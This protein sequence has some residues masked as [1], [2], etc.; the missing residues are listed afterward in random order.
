MAR[1]HGNSGRRNG[2]RLLLVY[3][4]VV[5]LAGAGALAWF[6]RSGLDV[7]PTG[8]LV[9]LV[10]GMIAGEIFPMEIPWRNQSLQVTLSST[11]ALMVLFLYG[12]AT[13]GTFHAVLWIVA[14]SLRRKGWMKVAFNAGQIILVTAAT[15]IVSSLLGVTP[16]AATVALTLDRTPELLAVIA[17][18]FAFLITN[19]VLTVIAR[20]LS[21]D[22]RIQ[23]VVRSNLGVEV[24]IEFA[25][26]LLVPVGLVS[27]S[28]GFVL[29][30]LTC[31]PIAA[32]Y[33]AVKAS[34]EN[35]VLHEER[36]ERLEA[37]RDIEAQLRQA[38]KMEA[39]GRLAG[40]VAHDFNNL[41][42]VILN[43]ARFAKDDLSEASSVHGDLDEIV[44]AAERATRLTQQLLS[45][46]RRDVI[47]PRVLQL[48]DVVLDM[49]RMLGRTI[50][51]HIRIS[52]DVDAAPSVYI[53]PGQLEQIILNLVVNARDA[54]PSGG[55]LV[56]RTGSVSVETATKGGRLPEGEFARLEVADTGGGIGSDSLDRI[57]EP[58][59][60]T[61]ERGEGT[62]LGLATVYGAVDQAGGHID[63]SSELGVGTVFSV[64]LP[65]TDLESR[66]PEMDAGPD[67]DLAGRTVLVVEDEASVRALVVRMLD[68]W[69]VR[70]LAASSG[71]EGLEISAGHVGPLDLVL[72]DVVMPRMSGKEFATALLGGRPGTPVLY[73]SGYTDDVVA[74]QGVLQDGEHLLR[75]PFDRAGLRKAVSRALVRRTPAGPPD[76]QP[77]RA[78]TSGA[79][80]D[81]VSAI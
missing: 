64:Y 10:L 39:I 51:E 13:A 40:G 19:Q 29:F 68:G 62:G 74:K 27:L 33:F 60:T 6:L 2:D 63:V 55:D 12:P 5:A 15:T 78:T 56:L 75:K 65:A 41:L 70:V 26:L 43:Y 44:G 53:D 7:R 49:G 72:T 54:M 52:V 67:L 50:G 3:V 9:V 4:V 28:H 25:A 58:F 80:V 17:A 16:G 59:F 23:D 21:S 38:Q 22:A 31:V 20:T 42:S 46:G 77:L 18:L 1:D 73:M 35:Q 66:V 79:W 34:L 61:K 76:V 71:H 47:K 45:F 48:D 81:R 30:G 57:F 11:F 69:G 24:L 8:V 37:Q 36:E 32:F 14:F